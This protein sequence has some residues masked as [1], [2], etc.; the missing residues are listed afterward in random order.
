MQIS[1]NK[2]Q[3]VASD[4]MKIADNVKQLRDMQ[5]SLESRIEGITSNIQVKLAQMRSE[6]QDIEAGI[7]SDP[8]ISSDFLAPSQEGSEQDVRAAIR[9]AEQ[10]ARKAKQEVG[11]DPSS[12]DPDFL[13]NLY[14]VDELLQTFAPPNESLAQSFEREA[15][16]QIGG[17]VALSGGERM[18]KD[19]ILKVQIQAAELAKCFDMNELE[20][21]LS[22]GIKE[23]AAAL[24]LQMSADEIRAVRAQTQIRCEVMQEAAKGPLTP[25]V[26]PILTSTRKVLEAQAKLGGTQ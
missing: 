4:I 18:D 13:Q 10:S 25:L 6:R 7:V 26:T 9:V 12:S 16:R 15:A 21:R 20:I 11:L 22:R 2:Q 8:E 14:K 3:M 24:N 1:S 19:E 23:V 17:S 5:V